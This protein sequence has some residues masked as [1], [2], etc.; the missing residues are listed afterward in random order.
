MAAILL[1]TLLVTLVVLFARRAWCHSG[2]LRN[3]KLV[4]LPP[5]SMGWSYIGETF[6]LYSQNPNV[7]FAA[8]QKRYGDIFKTHIL[9]CPCIMMASPE[10]AKFV[11]TSHAHLFK[12]TFPA[13]KERLLGPQAIFFHQGDYHARLRKLVLGSF[14]P[15]KIRSIVAHIES[16]ALHALDSWEDSTVNTFQEMK[17][18]I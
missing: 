7:F 6:K 12:P 15:A 16:I 18:V 14:L 4:R 3:K 17:R 9:G 10:A 13:S 5:G 8:K 11:L 2:F 1:I